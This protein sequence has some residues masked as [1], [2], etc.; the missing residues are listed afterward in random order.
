[1]KK[2]ILLIIVILPIIVTGVGGY[3]GYRFVWE[4]AHEHFKKAEYTQVE[5]IIRF[6]PKP[7][8]SDRLR[9]YAQ[10]AMAL[11]HFDKA[12]GAYKSLYSKTKDP[13]YKL[14]LGNIANQQKDY[15]DAIKIYNEVIS[16]NPNYIQAYV[17]LATVYMIKG[18]NDKATEI[19]EK[20]IKSNEN[21]TILYE[22]LASLM[23]DK[24]DSPRFSEA[25][26]NLKKLDPQ[27]YLVTQINEKK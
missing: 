6:F 14:I 3:F 17:N 11:N 22:L 21:S 27:N 25:V 20:G 1:M 19:A 24:K 18:N 8:N 9:I 12:S 15:D 26:A 5:K 16:L 23:M 7:R 4:K 2:K 13:S 10:T